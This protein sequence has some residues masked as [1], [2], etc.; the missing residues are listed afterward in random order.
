MQPFFLSSAEQKP[1]GDRY[2]ANNLRSEQAHRQNRNRFQ[3]RPA[4]MNPAE[5]LRELRYCIS[6]YLA[7]E[8]I[9]THRSLP[10]IAENRQCRF[11]RMLDGN[12]QKF[13][14]KNA[15]RQADRKAVDVDP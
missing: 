4:V 1:I 10:D 11:C 12:A 13:Y 8:N 15:T 14:H 9:N 2:S 5:I 6:K 7:R 3:Q